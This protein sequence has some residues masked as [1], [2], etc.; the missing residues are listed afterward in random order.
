DKE[1]FLRNE[2]SLTQ[3]AGRAA[4]NVDGL[5]IFY[6]DTITQSM[7]KTMDETDRRRE[8]QV[9]YNILHGITPKTINKS[10][11]QIMKQTSVL[12]IKGYDPDKPYAIKD[13]IFITAAEDIA[14]YKTIPQVE[15]AI[16]KIK[17]AMEKA[18][19]DLDFIEAAGLRDKMFG[20]QKMLEEM[21]K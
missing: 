19:R 16:T 5:V 18:A 21:K 20:M 17:K 8:K 12:D 15:K 11:E 1:G 14:E 6:A 2:K 9:A 7:R 10:I 13:E 4:R 3:T